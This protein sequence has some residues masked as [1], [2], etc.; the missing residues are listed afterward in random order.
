[1]SDSGTGKAGVAGSQQPD[2]PNAKVLQDFF[3]G[4]QYVT[5]AKPRLS[6]VPTIGGT[7]TTERTLTAAAS[8]AVLSA[9]AAFNAFDIVTAGANIKNRYPDVK[10][11]E[12]GEVI[13]V[14]SDTAITDIYITGLSTAANVGGDVIAIGE[15]NEALIRA[16][17]ILFEF[18]ATDN[19]KTVEISLGSENNA[20]SGA[21]V[22]TPLTAVLRVEGFSHA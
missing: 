1:M 19:V 7:A 15:T 6:V 20:L 16:E 3:G 21:T 10:A 11:I 5:T 12:V 22:P 17:L 2:N 14:E 8:N 18:S 13:I 4:G 9:R